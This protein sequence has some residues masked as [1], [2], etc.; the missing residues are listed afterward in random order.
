LN[1]EIKNNILKQNV[2]D[3]E[4]S[5]NEADDEED[6]EGKWKEPEKSW[7]LKGEVTA[8][9]RGY[10]TLL[11]ANLEIPSNVRP[12]PEYTD[13]VT[14][15]LEDIFK[16]R[17]LELA[18]DSIVRKIKDTRDPLNYRKKV[19]LNHKKS[20]KSL[21]QIYE[22]E[23]LGKLNK[24]LEEDQ[25][26]PRHV[27]INNNFNKYFKMLDAMTDNNYKPAIPEPTIKVKSQLSSIQME[28]VAPVTSAPHDVLAPEEIMQKKPE[29][30]ADEERS[31]QDKKRDRRKKKN[32]Q[33]AMAT[34]REKKTDAMALT[35]D[36][37]ALKMQAEQQLIKKSKMPG[38]NVEIIKDEGK[39]S[40]KTS[41][42]FFS[43]FQNLQEN[44]TQAKRRRLI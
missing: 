34:K 9:Q 43:K 5:D 32:K 8:E 30:V 24:G 40:R 11:E 13:E 36:P 20:E 1:P 7:Q 10:N 16:K 3:K 2:K 37:K 15:S 31:L 25:E 33:R 23:K 42:A 17:I 6:E 14:K 35:G 18:F 27:Q 41:T 26:D 29:L 39:K 44:E 22:D 21:A 4:I 28:D 12:G 38:S 19:E